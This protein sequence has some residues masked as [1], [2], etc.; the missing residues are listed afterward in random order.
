MESKADNAGHIDIQV[1]PN[2]AHD[3]VKISGQFSN[4][5]IRSFDGKLLL[6]GQNQEV[7]LSEL[8]AGMYFVNIQKL[9]GLMEVKT[10]VLR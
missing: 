7:N 2:P 10:L 6:S 1:Y 5:Q 4:Y 3:F 8:S 9:D